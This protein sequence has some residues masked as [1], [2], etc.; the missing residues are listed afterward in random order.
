MIEFLLSL[1]NPFS[2]IAKIVVD[3]SKNQVFEVG[4]GTV[5]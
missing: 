2:K 3:V 1:D 5:K 4:D